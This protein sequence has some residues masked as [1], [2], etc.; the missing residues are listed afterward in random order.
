MRGDPH[1]SMTGT[2]DHHACALAFKFLAISY[3]MVGSIHPFGVQFA[4]S[5]YDIC[6]LSNLFDKRSLNRITVVE[7]MLHVME[8]L[9][10]V[11][12]VVVLRLEVE[13]V[14]VV[15]VEV[16]GSMSVHGSKC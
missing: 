1:P 7:V 10:V 9:V 5:V 3:P 15:E 16:L 6:S 11:A 2:V 13:V 12:M 8:V 4:I 14:E